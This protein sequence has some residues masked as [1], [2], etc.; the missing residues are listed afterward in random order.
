MAKLLKNLRTATDA[1]EATL[2][3]EARERYVPLKIGIVGDKLIGLVNSFDLKDPPPPKEQKKRRTDDDED[4]EE[5]QE[6]EEPEDE[7]EEEDDFD[8]DMSSGQI[9]RIKKKDNV[10]QITGLYEP[11]EKT[12]LRVLSGEY[13]EE[14]DR[15]D[16]AKKVVINPDDIDFE[17]LADI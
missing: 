9:R 15:V 12:V 16:Q 10:D 17:Y 14:L 5:E 6:E 4:G 3:A 8:D 13:L 11:D 7:S 1:E 2:N